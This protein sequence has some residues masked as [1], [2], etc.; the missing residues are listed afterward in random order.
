M[1]RRDIA[2]NAVNVASSIAPPTALPPGVEI[3][4]PALSE[5]ARVLTPAALS[6]IAKAH[7][8]FESRRQDLL[9]RRAARPRE[10]DA[11]KFPAFIP[12][13]APLRAEEWTIAPQQ[14]AYSEDPPP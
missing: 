13:T 3:R 12:E 2:E 8:A 11:G 9:A 7:R 4:A 6:F 5:A 14:I 10:F 1:V